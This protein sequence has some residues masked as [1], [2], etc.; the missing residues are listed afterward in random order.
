QLQL[1][2]C[3]PTEGLAWAVRAHDLA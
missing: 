1:A 2:V 3:D